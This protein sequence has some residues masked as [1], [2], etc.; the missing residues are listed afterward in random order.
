MRRLPAALLLL[1]A[2]GCGDGSST[3]TAVTP[4]TTGAPSA[5]ATVAPKPAFAVVTAAGPTTFSTADHALSCDVEAAYARCDVRHHTF[6]PPA[7]PDD[8]HENWGFG[9][10]YQLGTSSGFFCAADSVLGATKVLAVGHG[11]RVGMV[12]CDVLA[13]GVGCHQV[14]EP[15]GFVVSR[16][17]FRFS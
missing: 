4:P 15:D 16:S 3:P 10:E 17:S 12:E 8:C 11:L 6:T 5:T 14:G 9:V 2:S 13:T 7:K 1:L